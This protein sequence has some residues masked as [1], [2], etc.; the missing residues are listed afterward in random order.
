MNN[1][2]IKVKCSY[3]NKDITRYTE[4]S[5]ESDSKL[6]KLLLKDNTTLCRDC[7]RDSN[8]R[9]WLSEYIMNSR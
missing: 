5:N 9:V 2:K 1:I 3:C 7:A 8:A 6:I 4:P